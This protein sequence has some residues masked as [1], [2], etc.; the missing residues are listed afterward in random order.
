MVVF[1]DIMYFRKSN[2]VLAV[3]FSLLMSLMVVGVTL[4]AA[5]SP[6]DFWV[7]VG[8]VILLLAILFLFLIAK[9]ELTVN[10]AGVYYRWFPWH[11]SWQFIAWETISSAYVRKYNAL[12]EYGGWGIKGTR[13]N[14]AF[15]IS[16]KYGLQLVLIEGRKIL[17]ETSKPEEL[18]KVIESLAIKNSAFSNE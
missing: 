8:I 13:K 17:I 16:G 5:N 1:N 15:N 18:Q 11:R 10:K 7:V 12:S 14:R 3:I 4:F 2:L 6:A 9:L